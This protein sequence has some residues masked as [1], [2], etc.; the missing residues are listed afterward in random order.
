MRNK[1]I[2]LFLIS[3]SVY[4][5]TAHAYIDPISGSMYLQVLLGGIV[6]MA[7][8]IKLYWRQV[9]T[10]WSN[11]FGAKTAVSDSSETRQP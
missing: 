11:F 7:G 8:I 9:K 6:G 3:L 1:F 10:A 5:V 2:V 4:P